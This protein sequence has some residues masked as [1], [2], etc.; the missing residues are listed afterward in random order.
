MMSRCAKPSS[1]RPSEHGFSLIEVLVTLAVIAGA[2]LPL[3]ALQQR[4]VEQAT[5]LEQAAMFDSWW[6]DAAPEAFSINP[7]LRCEGESDYGEFR[8]V[9]SC[10]ALTPVSR[11]AVPQNAAGAAQAMAAGAAL[12]EAM[13]PRPGPFEVALYDVTFTVSSTQQVNVAN[14]RSVKLLGWRR[15]APFFR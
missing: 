6:R 14:E 2:L 15:V 12:E 4:A 1:I 8:L 5:R 9:W 10:V 7:M 3:Y 11:N 13:Q